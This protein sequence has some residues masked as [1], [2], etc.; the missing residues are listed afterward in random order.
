MN[1]VC[2]HAEWMLGAPI[3]LVVGGLCHNGDLAFAFLGPR[4]PGG[5][6]IDMVKT[7]MARRDDWD[8]ELL[9]GSAMQVLFRKSGNVWVAML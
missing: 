1:A 4:R 2:P 5:R 6:P 7:S 9:D 3:E 8:V